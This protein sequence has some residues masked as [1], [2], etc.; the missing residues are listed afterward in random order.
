MSDIT[1]IRH[2]Q[3]KQGYRQPSHPQEAFDNIGEGQKIAVK[4]AEKGGAGPAAIVDLS[5]EAKKLL[6]ER[7]RE[8]RKK[9]STETRLRE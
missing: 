2:P 3:L 5:Q 1:S 4:R 6:K 9:D 8:P 7:E